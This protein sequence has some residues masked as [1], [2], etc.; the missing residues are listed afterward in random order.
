MKKALLSILGL[1]IVGGI[2][3]YLFRGPIALGLMDRVV[4]TRMSM[5]LIDQLPDG[6]H[7][8]LCGAGS[9]LPD[10][11][12]S[13]PC[14]AII[15]GDHLF[16][17]DSGTNSSRILSQLQVPHGEIDGILITHFHSDHIDGLGEMLL[18]AWVNGS[19][20]QPMP[21]YGPEGVEQIAQG[22]NRI[23]SQDAV[24]RTAHHGEEI[25]P[26][27]GTGAAPRP[28]PEP[29]AGEASVIFEDD[30]LKITAFSVEHQPVEPAVGYR[31]DY[32]GRSV[33]ISGDT[34]KS[35]NLENFAQGTDLLVHEA[36]SRKLVG[37]MTAGAKKAG[38]PRLAKI[39][40]DILDYHTSPVE[41]AESATAAGADHLLFYHIVP[42]LLLAPLE[43]VFIEGV[44]DAY[45]GPF[46][47]GRD[48]TLVSL[49]AGSDEIT[50][51]QL[52]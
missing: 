1:L 24:Y 3:A 42:P 13:G 49:P 15:A 9:P 28:F 6:L 38:R 32:K 10:P 52:L 22:L 20:S 31:F 45:D 41:A 50:V 36:L 47:V 18:Q 30:G 35:K 33:V 19:R 34:K 29:A 8:V 48:G 16:L 46:T 14:T 37:A 27:S 44:S 7:V 12:R 40:Q 51:E 17:V 25:V 5:N 23:Y 39:T 2:V 11:Q 43:A 4:A 21:L 26:S